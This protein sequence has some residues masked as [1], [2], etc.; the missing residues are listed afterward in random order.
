MLIDVERENNDNIEDSWECNNCET[1]NDKIMARWISLLKKIYDSDLVDNDVP[2]NMNINEYI[3]I[4]LIHMLKLK[5]G[6]TIT[7]LN[8]F[9]YQYKNQ[10]GGHSLVSTNSK[11]YSNIIDNIIINKNYLMDM[12]KNIISKFYNLLKSLCSMYNDINKDTPDCT[13]FRKKQ[14]STSSNDKNNTISSILNT[15][16]SGLSIFSVI[17]AFLG[18]AYKYSLFGIDKLFQG[19]RVQV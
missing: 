5:D 2:M 9:Y 12:D 15:L 3:I 4:W 19:F 14:Y 10:R 8:Y 18:I 17:P 1:D 7:N 16:I 6:N 11:D 13:Q